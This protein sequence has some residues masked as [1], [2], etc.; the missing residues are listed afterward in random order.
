MYAIIETGGKQYSV[1][2][3]DQVRV[4]KLD[5]NVGDT[6][7][8][9]KVVAVSGADGTLRTGGKVDATVSATIAAQGRGRKIEVFKFKRRKMYRRRMGHRQA[10]TQLRIES[11]SGPEAEAEAVA[12]TASE[13]QPSEE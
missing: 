5:G 2:P 11:I 6:V 9:D 12:E 13:E 3:G 7:E 1:S 10:Y 4:E 8:L